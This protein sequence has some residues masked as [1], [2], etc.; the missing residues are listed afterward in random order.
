MLEVVKIGRKLF[1]VNIAQEARL[2]QAK[3][4]VCEA[5]LACEA[6]D[7]MLVEVSSAPNKLAQ[8]IK[9]QLSSDV[10]V[11]QLTV[12]LK[13]VKSQLVAVDSKNL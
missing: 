12:E 6:A 2:L 1:S 7:A 13:E 3:S 4:R 8:F 5:Q 10:S 9:W 11:Q